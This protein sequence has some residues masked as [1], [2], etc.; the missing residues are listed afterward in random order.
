MGNLEA[1][2]VGNGRRVGGR[3]EAAAAGR[4]AAAQVPGPGPDQPEGVAEPPGRQAVDRPGDRGG[5]QADD[6]RRGL[7]WPMAAQHHPEAVPRPVG[8]CRLDPS[9]GSRRISR[10]VSLPALRPTRR[11]T[12]TGVDAPGHG[13]GRRG[14]GGPQQPGTPAE[15]HD[16]VAAMHLRVDAAECLEQVGADQH[17]RTCHSQ[18]VPVRVVLALVN[19]TG[20][21]QRNRSPQPVHRGPQVVQG[22]VPLGPQHL[23]SDD[24]GVGLHGLL[25]HAPD[26]RAAQ[27]DVVG[28]QQQEAWRH[29]D[30]SD[31]QAG[32]DGRPEAGVPV[33]EGDGRARQDAPDAFQQRGCCRGYRRSPASR[34][35][36]AD[37]DHQH[38]QAGVV[39]GGQGLHDGIEGRSGVLGY[40]HGEHRR[41]RWSGRRIGRRRSTQRLVGDGVHGHRTLVP[42]HLWLI[43]RRAR[44]LHMH[45]TG[46]QTCRR[47]QP[48]WSTSTLPATRFNT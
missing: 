38:L 36:I 12:I 31:G 34:R 33:Q 37:V 48:S 20:P 11:P 1:G 23:G 14:H 10:L 46:E 6:G 45:S 4:R 7:G 5:Q 39:L 29:T 13:G 30:R 16:A 32:G 24:A 18:H 15:F 22:A 17:R 3:H 44:H 25:H 19:L 26:R 35:R 8:H 41:R 40:Q 2:H 21:H 42:C 28:Q 9:T 27:Q 43:G 47:R